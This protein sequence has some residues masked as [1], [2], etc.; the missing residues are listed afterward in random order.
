MSK[1]CLLSLFTVGLSFKSVWRDSKKER[2]ALISIEYPLSHSFGADEA[3]GLLEAMATAAAA[4]DEEE[5]G[6]LDDDDADGDEFALLSL[7]EC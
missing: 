2:D 1:S 6:G 7:V 4:D 5:D 3:A